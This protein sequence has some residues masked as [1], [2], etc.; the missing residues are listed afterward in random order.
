MDG[1]TKSEDWAKTGARFSFTKYISRSNQEK[2]DNSKNLSPMN[3]DGKVH[4][5]QCLFNI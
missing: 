1:F 2:Y 4:A 5:D 3:L